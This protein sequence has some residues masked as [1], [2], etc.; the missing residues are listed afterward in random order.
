MCFDYCYLC[1]ETEVWKGKRSPPP[2]IILE[3]NKFG[4]SSDHKDSDRK[5]ILVHEILAVMRSMF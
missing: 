1:M 4:S 5:V 3:E 2:P